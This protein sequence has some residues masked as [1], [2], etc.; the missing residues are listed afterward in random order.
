M[1]VEILIN[2]TPQETRVAIVENGVLQDIHI[3]RLQKR[4]LVGNIYKGRVSR[5]LPGM[6]AAFIDIGLDRTGFLHTS[7]LFDNN[8][9]IESG[10]PETQITGMPIESIVHNGEDILVQVIKDPIGTKGARLTTR[11]SIPSRYLVFIPD[12]PCIGIS[13]RIEDEVERERLRSLILSYQSR[14]EKLAVGNEDNVILHSAIR[15]YEILKKGGFIVRTAAEGVADEDLFKDIEFLRKQ[16]ESTLVRAKNTFPPGIVYDDLPLVMR[17][18]RDLVHSDVE[19][20]RIDS[21]ETHQKV[22]E[23]SKHFIPEF[24]GRIEYYTG[25]HPILDLYSVDDEIQR[26]LNRKVQLKS[27][28]YLIIDQTEAMTTIDINTGAFVGHRNQEE[29][30]YKT[31]LEA[32]QI[33]ARQLRLRNL[34]GII[35]IDFIDMQ[36]PEHGRQVLRSLEKHLERDN[37]KI[38]VSELTSLGLVQ[39]TR[40]RTRESLEHILCEC[41]PTCNGR[42]SVKTPETVCYEIYREML[43]EVRQFDAQKLLVVASQRVVD[44]LLD[45]ESASVAELESFLGRPITFQVEPLYTQEQYDIVLL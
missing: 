41:C 24:L 2:V 18:M 28:G 3:E 21:K 9:D 25:D 15:E 30:I 6:Q 8:T 23:F 7:D 36:D 32:A 22:M 37:S 5:V 31:N 12:Y 14:I 40:K 38:T 42:G 20:I 39:L 27:G 29:T 34:G 35:I 17:T 10:L 1:S 13:Q 33:I 4:G 45:D 26:S 11:L 16:W 19:K 44:M 43:R